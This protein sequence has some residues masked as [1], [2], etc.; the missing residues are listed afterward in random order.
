MKYIATRETIILFPKCHGHNEMARD[1]KLKI[2]G[3]GFVI[4]LGGGDIEKIECVGESI[5]LK[6]KSQPE[7]TEKLQR[8]IRGY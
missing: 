7:D 1:L 8:I 2:T 3:A 5:S 4:G 6:I